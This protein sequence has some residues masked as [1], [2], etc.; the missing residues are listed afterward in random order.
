MTG[1]S[2]GVHIHLRH[3][4]VV[5]QTL[6]MTPTEE[7]SLNQMHEFSMKYLVLKITR[8]SLFLVLFDR[9]EKITSYNCFS[10]IRLQST[11][12]IKNPEGV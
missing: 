8:E 5:S 11:N 1:K 4:T 9:T 3:W 10:Q 12:I 6:M 7:A 2:V